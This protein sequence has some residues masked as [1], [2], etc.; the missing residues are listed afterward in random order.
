MKAFPPTHIFPAS[1]FNENHDPHNGEFSSGEGGSSDDKIKALK[2][3]TAKLKAETAALKAKT[4]ASREEHKK[5]LAALGNTAHAQIEKHASD[6]EKEKGNLDSAKTELQS[7]IASIERSPEH[8]TPEGEAK[9]EKAYSDFKQK[10]ESHGKALAKISEG[11]H[12][13]KEAIRDSM[14]GTQEEE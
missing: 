9:V 3:H 6:L 7:K 12:H 1:R 14:G 2:E 13:T 8:G 5:A 11:L 10:V 4:K